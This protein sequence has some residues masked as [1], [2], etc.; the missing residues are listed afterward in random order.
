MCGNRLGL[1]GFCLLGLLA[2]ACKAAEVTASGGKGGGSGKAGSGG[3]TA[4]DDGEGGGA[5]FIFVVKDAGPIV[6]KDMAPRPD[7]S[8]GGVTRPCTGLECQ[9]TICTMGLCKQPKCD[10][11]AKTTLSGRVFDPA[12]RVPLYNV[13][14]YVPNAPLDPIKDGPNCDRCDSSISGKPIVAALSDTKGDFVLENVPVV[15][16]LPL[17]IQIGKWRRE[18]TIPGVTACQDKHVDDPNL[19]RLPRNHMEGNI[20]KIALTTGGYDVLECLLRKIGIE[21]GEFTPEAGAGR[22]NLYGG[23]GGG[24]NNR[25]TV[26]YDP[27]V[28]GGAAFTPAVNL[29]GD[30]NN[31]KRYDIVL[32][33]CEGDWNLFDKTMAAKQN[34]VSYA[35]GG[36]RVFASHWHGAWIQF[37]V[38]PWDS[39]AKWVP[40]VGNGNF[41][42]MDQHDPPDPFT[43]AID[44]SFPKGQAFADWLVN[45][46][47]STR[48]GELALQ[49][50]KHTVVSVDPRMGQRW[51]YSDA[52][53]PDNGNT[54]PSGVQYLTFNT[55]VSAEVGKECGRTVFTDIHV[56]GRTQGT[57]VVDSPGPPFP[58]GCKT[59]DLT[60]QEKALEFMLFDLS[61]CI[62]P[63]ADPPMPPRIVE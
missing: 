4:G 36:G 13:L 25:P 38:P 27:A 34:L 44:S 54:Y 47:A 33:S 6:E 15:A 50:P 59:T 7:A 11:A 46:Q 14:L 45:V 53:P 40:G 58:G 18:V 16:S 55:P 39:V 9:Q 21:D 19:L 17:V 49:Q 30:A 43:A 10:G 24:F 26:G 52:I 61:S 8:I 42:Q 32:M 57:V 35:N 56:S 29:W 28:N 31:L 62:Q 48:K 23:K 5:G 2:F 60:A 51:I 20:P 63:D 22:V 1:V 37:G 41:L 3:G 12:G